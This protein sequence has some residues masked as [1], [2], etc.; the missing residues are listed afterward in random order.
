MFIGSLEGEAYV[1]GTI[2]QGLPAAIR[3]MAEFRRESGIGTYR[4]VVELESILHRRRCERQDCVLT[5]PVGVFYKSPVRAKV[6]I[7]QE[8]R[9]RPGLLPHTKVPFELAGDHARI[10][11]V[12]RE[13]GASSSA[14]R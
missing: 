6:T 5:A 1:L 14:D 2:R 7:P 3:R 13:A 9:N 10:R 4:Q 11:K 12:A 8:I